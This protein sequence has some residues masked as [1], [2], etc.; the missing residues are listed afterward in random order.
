MLIRRTV[1]ERVGYLDER[2]FFYHEDVDFSL[3]ATRAGFSVWYQPASV[4]LHRV[5]GSTQGNLPARTFLE[6]Q[7]RVVF[8]AKH[9]RGFKLYVV[10]GL[11]IVRFIRRVAESLWTRQPELAWNYAR[12]LLTGL[13][14]SRRRQSILR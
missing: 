12:G 6:A 2:F 4:I 14:K 5:S 1:F 7:S 13:D 9:I 11:E 8:F 3:R 10:I